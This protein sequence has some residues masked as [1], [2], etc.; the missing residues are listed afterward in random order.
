MTSAV[1]SRALTELPAD[2]ISTS[3]CASAVARGGFER[4]VVVGEHAG[5]TRLVAA[6]PHQRGQGV[7]VDVADLARARLDV[8]IDQLVAARDDADPQPAGDRAPR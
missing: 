8:R 1:M 3:H 4:G 5:Q 2:R 7:R 6:P